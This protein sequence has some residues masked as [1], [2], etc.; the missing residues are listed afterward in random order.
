MNLGVGARTE[1]RAFLVEL[2]EL[3]RD[4][5][6]LWQT[7]SKDY[8]DRT[9]RAEAYDQL[10]AK[11]HE[12]F[13]DATMDELKRRI[14]TLRTNFRKELKKVLKSGKTGQVYASRAWHFQHL[15]FLAD[16]EDNISSSD[17][18]DESGMDDLVRFL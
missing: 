13:P 1:E 3:Y 5:T 11:Y 15:M 8:N 4:L 2:I 14:N 12:R 10:L 17:F 16:Q 18:L 9:K 7:R 6:P